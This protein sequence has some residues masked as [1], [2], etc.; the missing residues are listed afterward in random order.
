[1]TPPPSS[2]A[3]APA[4]GARSLAARP[5]GTLPRADEVRAAVVPTRR[6]SRWGAG[7][8]WP[9]GPLATGISVG[10]HAVAL[11]AIVWALATPPEPEGIG[12]QVYAV[13]TPDLGELQECVPLEMPEELPEIESLDLPTL[14][15][16]PELEQEPCLE[17]L[18]DQEVVPRA[19]A[20]SLSIVSKR[21]TPPKVVEAPPAPRP[22]PAVAV[23]APAQPPRPPSRVR[24]ARC[25]VGVS[26]RSPS[27]SPIRSPRAAP[28]SRGALASR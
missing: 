5:P 23:R 10:L 25:R 8:R 24:A 12:A 11:A 2:L 26:V 19:S 9:F 18:E 7:R 13:L 20:L 17:P 4:G 21:V 16:E 6:R 14:P 15:E 28:A 1:M 22:E 27:R 3:V